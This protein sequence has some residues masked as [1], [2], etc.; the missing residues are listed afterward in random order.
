MYMLLYKGVGDFSNDV[1]TKVDM[2]NV[3]YYKF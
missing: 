2:R 1:I 3:F